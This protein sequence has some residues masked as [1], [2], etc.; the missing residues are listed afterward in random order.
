MKNPSKKTIT[1]IAV[2]V[3]FALLMGLPGYMSSYTVVLVSNILMYVVLTLGWAIFSGPTGYISLAPAAFFGTGVYASAI[4]SLSLPL[5]LIILIGGTASFVLAFLVGSLTLRLKGMYFTMFTFGLVEL[6]RNGLHW[7]EVNITGTVGRIILSADNKT[8]FYAMVFIFMAVVLVSYLI[9]RSRFGLALQS[10]G[11]SEEAAAHS[12]VNVTRVKALTFAVSAFFM[13]AA[14]AAMSM[15]WTYIDPTTAFNIQYSFMP[16]L[17]AIFGGAG[18]IYG[19]I[20]GATIFSIL[21]E[22]LTTKFPYYYMLIFG[23]TMICVIR[24]M[25]HGV[26]GVIGKWQRKERGLEKAHENPGS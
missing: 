20:V 22:V 17:M 21:E 3:F 13:G 2:A 7:Y 15:R 4:L 19:P 9:R 5:P 18:Q 16:V 26:E 14:G 10:I 1:F 24:F 11:E 23:L 8:V 12:G 25:P 6:V